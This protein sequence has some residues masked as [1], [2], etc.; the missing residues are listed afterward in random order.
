MFQEEF[1]YLLSVTTVSLR[2]QGIDFGHYY[3]IIDIFSSI[4]Q[5]IFFSREKFIQSLL[6]YIMF[7]CICSRL[8]AYLYK[9]ILKFYYNSNSSSNKISSVFQNLHLCGIIWYIIL[10]SITLYTFDIYAII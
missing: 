7:C 2:F 8:L 4:S 1:I 9:E 5:R 3:R 10:Y 6:A